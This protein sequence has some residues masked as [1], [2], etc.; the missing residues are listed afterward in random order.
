MRVGYIV[1]SSYSGSTLLSFMLNAHPS[2]GTISEFD[3][4]DAVANDPDFLC[5]CGEKI[6]ECLF[7]QAVREKMQREGQ[8]FSVDDMSLMLNLSRDERLNRLLTGKLPRLQSN[9][10]EKIRDIFIQIVPL[11]RRR[12]QACHERTKCFMQIILGV[13]GASVF[14][15]ATKDPYRMLFLAQRHDVYAIYLYKNGIAGAYSYMKAAAN[16]GHSLTMT[17]AATRW[18]EEQITI[19][20]ALQNFAADRQMKISYSALC[21]RPQAIAA[22]VHKFLGLPVSSIESFWEATHH[23]VGNQMRLSGV[24]AIMEREDW[25]DALNENQI[26][27]YRRLRS[28]YI[29]RLEQLFPGVRKDIWEG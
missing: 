29:G 21:R 24:S 26:D 27:E 9:I 12:L 28:R 2:I 22:D 20:R 3:N 4:M 10:V 16:G 7:F 5:S 19:L 1:S 23:I 18:F 13:Q 8:P 11:Y 14:L 15:D 6:R 17:E 25:K